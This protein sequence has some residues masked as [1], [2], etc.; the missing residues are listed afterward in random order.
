MSDPSVMSIPAVSAAHASYAKSPA[1]AFVWDAPPKVEFLIKEHMTKKFM[2]NDRPY[3]IF[4]PSAWGSCLRKIAYQYY[5]EHHKFLPKSDTDID[6]RMERLFDNGHA[7]HARWRD[8]LDG[9]GILRGMWKC[10]NIRCGKTY[11]GNDPLGVFNPLRQPGWA[12]S[13]GNNRKFEYEELSVVSEPQYNFEGH[14]DAVVDVRGLPTASGN[15]DLDLFVVDFKSMKSDYFNELTEAKAEHVIQV[16]IYM[17]VLNLK[18]AV[19]IY[20]NKDD[21]KVKEMFVKRS[22]PLIEDLKAQ[23]KWLV[24]V[25]CHDKLPN[26]PAGFTRS[27]FPCRLCEFKGICFK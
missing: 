26:R 11:G 5:N 9:A 13:C 12:C 25:L 18:T 21:Q 7:M 27:E 6:F 2:K 23:S 20:E 16:H 19:V 8:Y 17:W 15:P 3:D 14:C 10:G 4:H 1:P 24:D 22:E